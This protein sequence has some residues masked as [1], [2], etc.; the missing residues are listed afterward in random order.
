M[1]FA[2]SSGSAL[3]ALVVE[4]LTSLFRGFD[5]R[6]AITPDS[7]KNAWHFGAQNRGAEKRV[8]YRGVL[9]CHSSVV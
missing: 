2:R 3:L 9:K 1:A 4:F 7:H 6:P 5:R 8:T